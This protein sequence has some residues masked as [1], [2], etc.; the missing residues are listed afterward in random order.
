MVKSIVRAIRNRLARSFETWDVEMVV[1]NVV[2]V[3]ALLIAVVML[4]LA[5]ATLNQLLFA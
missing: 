4:V 2:T 1:V 5:M 3:L